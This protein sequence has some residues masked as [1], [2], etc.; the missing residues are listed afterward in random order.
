[1]LCA[2]SGVL[3]AAPPKTHVISLQ[4]Y[5]GWDAPTIHACAAGGEWT[6][7]VMERDASGAFTWQATVAE[8]AQMEEGGVAEFVI[9]DGAGDWDKSPT[10]E[11][12]KLPG[13]GAFSLQDGTL[14]PVAE[15]AEV[16]A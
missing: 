10:G 8:G 11:N 3:H 1:M 7:A 14:T 4:Y 13:V 9:T 6:S 5:S 2:D 15:G 16:L 12:Y